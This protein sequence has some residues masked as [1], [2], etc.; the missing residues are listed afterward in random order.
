[1][2]TLK[3]ILVI[4]GI[5]ILALV[6]ISQFLPGKYHVERSVVMAAKPEVIHP[7]INNLKQWQDWSPWTAAKDPTVV[8]AYEGP[9]EGVG[10]ISK[11]DSKQWGQGEMKLIASDP[12]SGLKFDLSFNKGKY[13]CVGNFTFEAAENGTKVTWSMDGDVSRNPLDRFFSLLMDKFAG[14]D[15]EEGL[16]GL[17]KKVE[18]KQP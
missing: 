6:V 13:A 12:A 3:K 18:T 14:P 4:V 7:L 1:M 8:Y 10:A 2:K 11:W 15:F 5:V 17:K 16:N 9:E